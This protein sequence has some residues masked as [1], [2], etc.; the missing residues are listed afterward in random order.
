ML[1][2]GAMLLNAMIAVVG[3]AL[4]S[5]APALKALDPTDRLSVQIALVSVVAIVAAD[6]ARISVLPSPSFQT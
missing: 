1:S 6:A 2:P 3:V 5:T 4:M